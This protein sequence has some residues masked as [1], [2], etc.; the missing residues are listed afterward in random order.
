MITIE[1][2]LI[3]NATLLF[4]LGV[5]YEISYLLPARWKNTAFLVKGLLIGFVCVLV[6]SLPFEVE[7]GVAIDTRSIMLSVAA[8]IFGT[9]PSVIAAIIALVYRVFFIGGSGTF[10]GCILIIC[11]VIIGLLWRKKMRTIKP[12]AQVLHL[13]LMGLV[14][15]VVM[16][17]CILLIPPNPFE[18]LDKLSFT[19]MVI[20]PIATVM[21]GMLLLRQRSRNEEL[22]KLAEAE[23][24][25]RSLF[26][27]NHAVLLLINPD[28]GR[29]IDANPAA[30]SYYGWEHEQLISMNI[31]EINTLSPS[32]VEQ[33]MR[34]AIFEKRH[35]F[36]FKHRRASGE[37]ADVE[38]YS[39]PIQF[40]G[41]TLLYSIVHDVSEQNKSRKELG[42][43]EQRFRSVV[44]NAPDAIYITVDYKIVYVN[45]EMVRLMGAGSVDDLLG[46]TV[47]DHI[48]PQYHDI[49]NQRTRMMSEASLNALSIEEVY[50]RLDGSYISVDVSAV[51][52][53]YQ[54]TPGYLVFVRDVSERKRIENLK[55]EMEA[56]QRQQQKLES[57]GTLAGGVAHEI[58]N[59]IH[60]IMN[61]AELILDE[62]NISEQGISYA[63]EIIHETERI[64]VIVKNLLQFSRHEK[65]THSYASVY[66]IIG[67]TISL[68]STV[69]KKD[70]ISLDIRL[71]DGL[72]EIK[73]RSQQIQQVLMNLLTNARDALNMRYPQYDENK[74]IKVRCSL[75]ERDDRR[76]VL[77]SVEDQGVGITDAVRERMFDP[78]YSTKPRETGTGL[79]LSISHG[80][81]KDHH[82]K[83]D[84]ETKL[85]EYT[86]FM[87][88]L[89]VDNG[90]QL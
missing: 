64:S 1:I 5:I 8:I 30:S 54:D 44:E 20:F 40:S 73:C 37:V 4:A 66:D 12:K 13:Y 43:S 10:A 26:Q 61:Y 22:M 17:L 9:V 74:V 72:P 50:V 80:I 16:L 68:I 81:V 11:S 84:V 67:Q 62:K 71:D 88:E 65:Q 7:K 86:R 79:G 70:Q 31:S 18:I 36:L 29:I 6:M 47:W 48:H 2:A 46:R 89:P 55:L 27:N 83:I 15:H 77:I 32:E 90:W 3:Y 69:I 57:I 35:Y 23:S 52:I 28:T 14:V 56:Q 39:G 82:G 33:E 85:G 42:E 38:V 34:K 63:Q 24:R 49:V 53:N 75:F 25:Y 78:F 45:K 59:P 19:I 87:V 41:Q 76:W 51:A 58:N 21:L 60:G